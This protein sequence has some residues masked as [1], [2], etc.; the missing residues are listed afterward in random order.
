MAWPRN[1]YT[2]PGGG[3]YTGPGGGLTNQAIFQPLGP[4]NNGL[5]AETA[6]DGGVGDLTGAPQD[7]G[8]FKSP[9]L[10]NVAV[11][12]PY[13]H[14]GRFATLAEVVEFYDHGVQ[15]HPN[16]DPR[17]RAPGG[18]P[19]RLGLSAAEKRALVAFLGTLTDDAL[20]ADPKF[21]DPFVR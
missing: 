11:S 20:R 9:S 10:R 21:G 15:A 4:I 19:R 5:D 12:A 16:L 3:A 7:D 13:M 18:Q 17:L 8:K 1:Q 6:T 2:G 14:D